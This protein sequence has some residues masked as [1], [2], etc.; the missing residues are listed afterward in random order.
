M[1]VASY[2]GRQRNR[3]LLSATQHGALG[4]VTLLLA[5]LAAS[6]GLVTIAVVLVLVCSGFSVSCHRSLRLARRSGVGA[7][8]EELVRVELRRLEHEGWRVRHSLR[9]RGGGDI[10]HLAVA[11]GPGGLVF[12]I[13]TKTRTYRP[14]DLAR[15]AAVADWQSQRRSGGGR[16]RAIA[17]LCLAGARRVGRWEDG[18]AVVSLDR[19]V[20]L[21]SRLAGTTPKPLFLR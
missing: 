5:V 16:Q 14:G 1:T 19:L 13:E 12:A 17:I 20:A 4:L 15:I 21:M 8:S 10:D 18:V 9:W 6:A 3:R 2:P 11:P 7:R